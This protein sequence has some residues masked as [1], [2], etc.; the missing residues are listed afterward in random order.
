MRIF[1]RDIKIEKVP[2]KTK[3]AKPKK[4]ME[5]SKK[6]AWW[7]VVVATLTIITHY[8]LTALGLEPSADVTVAIVTACISYLVA[9]AAKSYGEKASRNKYGLDADGNPLG[10][11]SGT[12]EGEKHP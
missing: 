1:G 4:K 6:L 8:T 7:A 2:K 10:A 5:T 3:K 11:S 9:Y 12:T